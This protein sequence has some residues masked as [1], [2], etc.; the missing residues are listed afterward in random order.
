MNNET[1]RFLFDCLFSRWQIPIHHE[2]VLLVVAYHTNEFPAEQRQ[3][4]EQFRR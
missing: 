3:H 1:N 4:V 2:T